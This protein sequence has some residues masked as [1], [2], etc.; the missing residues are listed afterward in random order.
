MTCGFGRQSGGQV[1]IYS[2]L[3]KGTTVC[4]YLPRHTG[5]ADIADPLERSIE[6]L[7][8]EREE[9]VLVVDDEPTVR[10]LLTDM[11]KELGYISIAASDGAVGLTILQSATDRSAHYRPGATRWH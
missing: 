8:A 2:E 4:L 11:L 10:M 5:D 9:T 1:H 6:L 3:G 7:P